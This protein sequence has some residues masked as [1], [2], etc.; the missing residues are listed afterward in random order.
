L[1]GQADVVEFL[2]LS[3]GDH[4]GVSLEGLSGKW[5]LFPVEYKRGRAKQGKCDI[6]QLCAQAI[7]LEEMLDTTVY[8]GALFYCRQRRRKEVVFNHDIRRK[9]E[10]T[11]RRLHELISKGKTPNV[12]YDKK[13]LNCSLL[14]HCMPKVTGVRKNLEHYL[15]GS[16]EAYG[17]HE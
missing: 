16:E 14:T 7:C 2:Q 12:R 5:Q 4:G 10:E 9:T 15:H 6:V 11:A 3:E 13:C 1:V 17:E 8:K